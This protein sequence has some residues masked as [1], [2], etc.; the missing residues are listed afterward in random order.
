MSRFDGGRWNRILIWT[1]AALAW[2][3]ALVTARIDENAQ[4]EARPT[5]GQVATVSPQAGMPVSPAHGL[6]ILRF[7]RVESPEPEVITVNVG[8]TGSP[9]PAAPG[10][11]AAIGPAP[12]PSSSGS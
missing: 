1:G 7:T 10:P 4:P 3:T 5:E 9:R 11:S 12:Q 8:R 6:V 2:G